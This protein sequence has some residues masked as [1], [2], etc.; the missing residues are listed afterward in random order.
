[1]AKQYISIF[2]EIIDEYESQGHKAYRTNFNQDR[3][4]FNLP[5]EMQLP[6]KASFSDETYMGR[7]G[8]D[9]D[10][11]AGDNK[12]LRLSSSSTIQS[13]AYWPSKAYLIVS[14][15]SGHTYSYEG[16]GPWVIQ[17]WE[18]ANSA[19]SFFYW[20]IRTSFKYQ[21]MG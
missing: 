5:P 12:Q 2:D 13:A 11:S 1:M 6:N 19:G 16:V 18:Q 15:K 17:D 10:R 20:N 7:G 8:E 3:A 21:K 9:R 14:F 4:S